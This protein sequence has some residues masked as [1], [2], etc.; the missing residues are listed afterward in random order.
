L[1][2]L[3]IM[4]PGMDGIEVLTQLRR[5]SDAYVIIL[6]AKSEEVDKVVGL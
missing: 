6:T 4:L 5:E 3:D 1:I 2:V